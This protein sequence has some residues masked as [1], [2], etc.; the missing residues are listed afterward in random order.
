MNTQARREKI[1]EVLLAEGFCN[2]TSLAKLLGVSEVT[3]RN[4]LSAL[5][6]EGKVNRIHGGAILATERTRGGQFEE[7]TSI[8]QERKRWIAR[9]AAELVENYDS[10]I[11]DASTTAFYMAHYLKNQQGLTAFTNGIEVAFRLAENRSNTVALTGGVL[12]IETSS[13]TGQ[14]G[15]GVLGGVRARKAFLSCTGWSPTLELMD[16]DLFEAQLKKEMVDAAESVIILV[17]SSKFERQGVAAFAPLSR[18]SMVITDDQISSDDL[19]RLREAGVRVNIC[20]EHA[21]RVLDGGSEE[22]RMRIG[23]AN[24]DDTTPFPALVRQGLVQAAEAANVE[25]LLAD[26]HADGPTALANVECFVQEKVDLVVEFNTDVRYGNVI[27]ER[28]RSANI[29]VIA[30]DIPMP[31]AT[32]VGVDNYKAG[33]MGGRLLGHF[34]KQK[35]EGRIDKVLSLELPLSGPIPAARMQGQIDGLRELIA[36][37]EDNIFHLDSKNTYAE[38][39]HAVTQVLPALKSADHIALFGINDETALGAIKAFEEAGSSHRIVAVGQ[40]TDQLALQELERADSRLI[41]SVAFFPEYYGKI[42][43][44]T[45]V[46]IL[47]GKQAPPA[48]YI[49]HALVLSE[50]TIRTLNLSSLPYE[51]I[52]ILDYHK[53]ASFN[54]KTSE[55]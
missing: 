32:F 48:V 4:D 42:I 22:K 19:A 46:Q 7:R 50:E 38:A 20:S 31:G 17:D 54:P 55:A 11:L 8:N 25:L 41:G 37:S 44:D 24:Q 14:F 52:S 27:M 35:W 16:D 47:Q 33:L 40:G 23:F 18:I 43:I 34:V 9:R 10:I 5:E 53:Y 39:Y 45:A 29:P 26:N 1:G 15:N 21:T 13:L 51:K 28:L 49:N 12:R 2:V 30:V 3:I 6:D 36:I